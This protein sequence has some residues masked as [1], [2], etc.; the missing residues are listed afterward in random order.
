M[1]QVE[2]RSK[3]TIQRMNVGQTVPQPTDIQPRETCTAA[4]ADIDLKIAGEEGNAVYLARWDEFG[5]ATLEQLNTMVSVI[6]AREAMGKVMATL[7]WLDNISIPRSD[8]VPPFDDCASFPKVRTD[9]VPIDAI[10]YCSL[11]S[12]RICC[13]DAAAIVHGHR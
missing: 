13:F 4:I 12:Y 10:R 11:F 1:K 5:Y 9:L 8:V 6:N 7:Q 3:H 2:I